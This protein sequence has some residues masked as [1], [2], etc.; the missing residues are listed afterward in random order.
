MPKIRMN[1][2]GNDIAKYRLT[3]LEGN[4]NVLMKPAP[5]KALVSNDNASINGTLILHSPTMRKVNKQDITL[6]FMIKSSSI[7]DLQRDIDNLVSVL[8]N[9]IGGTGINELS[10]PCLEK[11]YRLIYVSMDKY[12]NFGFDGWATLNIKFTEQDPTQRQ[13]A[14]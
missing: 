2:N 13:Y 11:T 8:V 4:L 12:Q 3:S 7:I 10:V 14:L 6:S 5:Y 1:L 9:G